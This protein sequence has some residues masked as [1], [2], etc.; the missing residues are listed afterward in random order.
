VRLEI[1]AGIP[2]RIRRLLREKLEI[3]EEDVYESTGPLGLSALM[4]L[5]TLP[6]PDLRDPPLQPRIPEELANP[7]EVFAA[8]RKGDLL[9][10]HPYDSFSPV[11]DF[12]RAAADD[13]QVLAIKMTLYRAGSNS[14][15]VRALIRACENGKQ[16]AVSVELKA[17]FDEEAN[18]AWARALEHAGAHVFYGDAALKTHAKMVLVVRREG[19][20]LIRYVHLATGNYNAGTA[21]I[22]TDLGLLTADLQLGEEASELFNGLSGFS[23]K[24]RYRKLA[25]APKGLAEAV[26]ARIEEQ[27]QRAREGK[28]ARI[29]AKLNSVV[30]GRAI[31]ALYRASMAGVSIDLCVRGICCLRPGLPGI[32]ENIRVFSIVG[33]FLEHE[34]VF[35]FGPPGSETMFLSSADWMPRNFDRRVEVMFPVESERLRQQIREEVVDPALGDNAGAYVL[36]PDGS[37]TRRAPPP[38]QPPRSAQAEL[39]ERIGKSRGSR[40]S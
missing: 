38:D 5:A 30:D 6:R 20:R 9:L 18:I 35:V 32:S 26:L 29:F 13:P 3:D 34:R 16:V 14:E 11:L 27:A 22:Y 21:R 7:G 28:P 25:V 4:S 36:G 31:Q 10:H 33:R 2:D 23:K 39:L 37:Y 12:L 19:E 15:A 17:R 1:D 24:S 8:I 40:L